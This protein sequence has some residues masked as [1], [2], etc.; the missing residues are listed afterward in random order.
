MA[1]SSPNLRTRSLPFAH[2]DSSCPCALAAPLEREQTQCAVSVAGTPRPPRRPL[3]PRR[4]EL[5]AVTTNTTATVTARVRLRWAALAVPAFTIGWASA[6]VMGEV[7]GEAW[8]GDFL[9]L[10]GHAIGTVIVVG[11]VSLAGWLALRRQVRW[12]SRSALATTVGAS[13]GLVLYLPILALVPGTLAGLTIALS[14]HLPLIVAAVF[15][16]MALRGHLPRPGRW[17]SNRFVGILVGVGV[18]WFAGGGLE[19]A[20]AESVHPVFEKAVAYWWAMI[21]RSLAGA[22]LFAAWTALSLPSARARS[23]GR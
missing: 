20:S 22:L 18:A 11:L 10:L 4:P 23:N 15:Q 5:R 21:P 6:Q 1:E 14:L 9:H 3:P 12:T 16:A 8:G 19:G 17:A 2:C 13:V 7:V